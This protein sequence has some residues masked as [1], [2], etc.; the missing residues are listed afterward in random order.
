MNDLG[1]FEDQL[2]KLQP[3]CPSPQLAQRIERALCE[4]GST[5]T[6]AVVRPRRRIRFDWLALGAGLA[7][8]A[9]LLIVA[10]L[11]TQRPQSTPQRTASAPSASTASA[12]QPS[13]ILIPEGLT[14]VVY[15]TRDEGVHFA[16]GSQQPVRRVRSRARET[17]SWRNLNTGASLRISYPA[18]EVALIPVSGQ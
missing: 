17:L 15:D 3:R 7:A 12:L 2:R 18:E 11:R 5:P 14:R 13:S 6:A 8:A 4:E 16:G 10:Q 1:E 9:L